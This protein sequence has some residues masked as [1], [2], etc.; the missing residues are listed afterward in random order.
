M[1]ALPLLSAAWQH[2]ALFLPR[3]AICLSDDH[4]LATLSG[5]PSPAAHALF[6]ERAAGGWGLICLGALLAKTP[7]VGAAP[8]AHYGPSRTRKLC[9][10]T[11]EH[12]H[13]LARLIAGIRAVNPDVP[14]GCQLELPLD[15]L[16]R[17]S[18]PQPVWTA[19]LVSVARDLYAL[20][21]RWFSIEDM[22][23]AELIYPLANLDEQ[24]WWDVVCDVIGALRA[25]LPADA[26]V[27]ARLRWKSHAHY[28]TPAWCDR[29]AAL[30]RA[31]ADVLHV[32]LSSDEPAVY[33]GGTERAPVAKMAAQLGQS[34][35]L[36]V[37]YSGRMRHG[38]DGERALRYHGLALVG[39][40][41]APLADPDVLRRGLQ[42]NNAL[43]CTGCMACMPSRSPMP[44]H[45]VGC[46]L[47]PAPLTYARRGQR[48]AALHVFG[49]SLPALVAAREVAQAGAP[50]TMYTL[51]Q[52]LG[53]GLR[54][55]GRTPR[56]AE[57]AEAALH[58]LEQCRAASVRIV[59]D[60]LPP[61]QLERIAGDRVLISLP[62]VRH[63]LPARLVGFVGS[64]IDGRACLD[65]SGQ[66][67][68]AVVVWGSG[69]LAVEL[70][71]FFDMQAIP[72]CI[73]ADSPLCFDTHPSLAAFYTRLL[74]ER[75][76]CVAQARDVTIDASGAL[77]VHQFKQAVPALAPPW[78]GTSTRLVLAHQEVQSHPLI[79]ALLAQY[80]DAV[81][82]P[83]PYEPLALRA[84]MGRV[85]E[86]W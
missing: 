26:A 72:V 73:A 3:R 10:A 30:A 62:P 14:L 82:L 41:R 66:P 70:A 78:P 67:R 65:L 40:L 29:L 46:S 8:S 27:V 38:E 42:G 21:L 71:F 80:P 58:L 34:A 74:S 24:A 52:T 69:L 56:Q 25:A 47:R 79:P 35:G 61:P 37:L 17:L 43:H 49:A 19:R 68:D 5:E 7:A 85:A 33:V 50:V 15:G 60:K 36:P 11:T 1:S 45:D 53:G 6:T 44:F 48:P 31:G 9:A 32:A 55:R 4:G 83:D 23:I 77:S 39:F 20:G 84:S 76:I 18:E 2:K 57:S 59:K 13:Q 16:S 22:H 28:T 81:L 64:V 86:V 63:E 12:Q 51:G 75:G 54:Q